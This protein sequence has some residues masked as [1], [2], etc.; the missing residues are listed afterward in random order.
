MGFDVVTGVGT[1]G[2]GGLFFGVDFQNIFAPF[3]VPSPPPDYDIGRWRSE[4]L[5]KDR[6]RIVVVV[7]VLVLPF[8][9]ERR[10]WLARLPA[11]SCLAALRAEDQTLATEN[12]PAPEQAAERRPPNGR[13]K[14]LVPINLAIAVLRVTGIRLAEITGTIRFQHAISENENS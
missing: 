2:F 7:E 8:P 12:T 5:Q 4:H 6:R 9:L 3:R 1:H 14:L 13:E 10:R 11:A